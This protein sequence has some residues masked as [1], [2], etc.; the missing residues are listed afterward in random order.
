MTVR[1]DGRSMSVPVTTVVMGDVVELSTGVWP[2]RAYG[3]T[4]WLIGPRCSCPKTFNGGCPS[5]GFATIVS[6][7][8]EGRRI[9]DNI[10]R[11][12]RYLLTTSAG[13]LWAM[14]VA[15]LIGLPVPLLAV[16]IL[17]M[18][19]VTD[20]LPAIALGI[21]PVEPDA[22]GRAPRPQGE[23]LFAGGLWQPVLWVGLLMATTVVPLEAVAHALTPTSS[24]LNS[25]DFS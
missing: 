1:R 8:E 19:L 10:R 4:L 20:G 5:S 3:S 14:V 12:V 24:E 16:Q 6:A 18:N 11:V 9:Y 17:W 22:M 15:P 25:T 7:I 2:A 21:E 23:S 13:E